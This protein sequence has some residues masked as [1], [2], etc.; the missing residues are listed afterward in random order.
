MSAQGGGRG[1][2]LFVVVV[3]ARVVA[4]HEPPLEEP[5]RPVKKDYKST[6]T[7]RPQATATERVV[8]QAEIALIPKRSGEDLLRL[9]PSLVMTRHGAEGKA[10]QIFLRGFDA[11][12]GADLETLVG[13]IPLNELSNI[14]GQ[15]YLDLGIVIPEVVLALDALKGSFQVGQGN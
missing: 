1:L 15:G 6:V 3:L 5:S 9:V 8:S 10:G 2:V 4:A 14:H 11:V 7:A 12:H 13:G